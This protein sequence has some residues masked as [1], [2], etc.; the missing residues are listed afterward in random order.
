MTTMFRFVSV[1]S[2]NFLL[3]RRFL[4]LIFTADFSLCMEMCAWVLVVLRDGNTSIQDQPHSGH[5]QTASTEP[6]KKRI[7]EITE[8]D[9]RVMMDIIATKLGIGNN[10]VQEMIGSLSYQKIWARW[11][12]CLLNEDHKVQQKAI[13]SEI[14][15]RYRDE[16]DDFLLSIVTGDNR[17][18]HHFDPETKRQSME[19]HHLDSPTKK[20]PK[21]MPSAKKI[22]GTIFWDAEGC[23]FIEFLEPGKTI[24]AARYVQT[25][26]KLRRA[27]RDKCPRRKVILQEHD[28]AQPHTARLT[29]EK[30]ENMWWEVLPHPLYSPDLAPSDYHFFGFVNNNNNNNLDWGPVPC[31]APWKHCSQYGLLYDSPFSKRSYSGCQVSLA[32]TTCGS[33]LAARGGTM[34]EKWWPNGA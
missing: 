34:D 8:E 1:L 12:P 18:F 26:L 31:F 11:V 20:K 21:T 29:L 3:K 24:I 16:G 19:W 14:L 9:R 10:A 27:L 7:D 2:L 33:P 6:N 17:W 15:Q 25:L 4:L 13:T 5:P 28:N 23:I 32:S 22:T 30:I